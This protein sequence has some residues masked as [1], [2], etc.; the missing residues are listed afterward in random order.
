MIEQRTELGREFLLRPRGFGR[1]LSAG[2]LAVWLCFWT[3]GEGIVLWILTRGTMSLLSGAPPGPGHAPLRLGPA[4]AVGSFLLVWLALWTVGGIA[5][6]HELLRLTVARDH[7]SAGPAG[8]TVLHR[9]GP[10]RST[11]EIPRDD[12]RRVY[13]V[14]RTGVLTAEHRTGSVSLSGLGTPGEREE[15]AAA[16]RAELRLE[17]RDTADHGAMALPDGWQEIADPE[18]GIALV[19]DLGTRRKQAR[20]STVVALAASAVAL[21]LVLES[22]KDPTLLPLAAMACTAAAGMGWGAAWLARG[23]LEW[24]IGVGSVT[25]R[26]RFGGRVSDRFRACRLEITES[27]DGD[28]D[29]WYALDAIAPDAVTLSPPGRRQDRRTVVKRI[30]D[31]DVPRRIGRWLAHRAGIPLEDRATEEARSRDLAR[32]KEQ[33]RGAG[34]FGPVALRWIERFES[35]RRPSA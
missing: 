34:R 35:R 8:L 11:R 17:D 7:V 30:H 27:R 9:L 31:P 6:M 28:G 26:R 25:Q 13:L 3:A 10:F 21:V 1:F 18:V 32:L 15:I 14:P 24:R 12:L 22:W 19:P 23:R 29:A 2:F 4:L 16:L 5:A 33:L 20:V